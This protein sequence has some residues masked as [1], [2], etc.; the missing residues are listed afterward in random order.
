[1]RGL[2][3]WNLMV[4]S[5]V[6]IGIVAGCAPEPVR[7]DAALR[8]GLKDEPQILV[9][10]Y[11]PTPIFVQTR[12]GQASA[13]TAGQAGLIGALVSLGA[14]AVDEKQR[15]EVTRLVLPDPAARVRAGLVTG[16][17][18]ELGLTNLRAHPEPLASDTLDELSRAVGR[19]LALDVGTFNWGFQPDQ[20]SSSAYLVYYRA[21]ARL[22][23]VEDRKVVWLGI[24]GAA[25]AD[26]ARPGPSWDEFLANEGQLLKE[27]TAALADRCA[28]ELI[29]QLLG[30]E[31]RKS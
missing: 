21:R 17:A 30:R 23:R 3:Q 22:I 29:D 7:L 15:A 19:G 14:S 6:L 12:A 9:I 1:M 16:L 5:G 31:A 4:L 13:N 8:A 10:G 27:K 2:S 24:C 26:P 20:G 28:G 25:P 11:K 18:R